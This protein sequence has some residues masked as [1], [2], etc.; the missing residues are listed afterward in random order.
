LFGFT[1]TP[2]LFSEKGIKDELYLL[3]RMYIKYSTSQ[4]EFAKIVEGE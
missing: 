4:E 3:P 2:E 1:T